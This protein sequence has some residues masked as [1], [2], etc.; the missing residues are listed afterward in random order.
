V[1][2]VLEAE[3]SAFDLRGILNLIAALQNSVTVKVLWHWLC[4]MARQTSSEFIRHSC[5]CGT[6]C[7]CSACITDSCRVCIFCVRL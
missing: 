5:H 2:V 4:F 3:N 7:R 6:W 1:K